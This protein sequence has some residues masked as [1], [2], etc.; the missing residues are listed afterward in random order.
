MAMTAGRSPSKNL[1]DRGQG[2]RYA[3]AIRDRTRSAQGR[4]GGLR[5]NGGSHPGSDEPLVRRP[6]MGLDGIPGR[7]PGY[8]AIDQ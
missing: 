7:V 6:G 4:V 8:A 2:V 1:M 5:P 3:D